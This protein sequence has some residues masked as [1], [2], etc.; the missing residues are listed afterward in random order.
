MKTLPRAPFELNHPRAWRTY[1]GGALLDELHGK[2]H[3]LDGHFPEEWIA[4]VISTRNPG[5][6]HMVNE[7]LSFLKDL[8]ECSLRACLESA[9]EKLLG[10]KHVQAYGAHPGVLVKLIDAAERLTIQVHPDRTAAKRLFNSPYGKT[11]CWHI[12]GGRSIH[13]E[14]PCVYL[15][16]QKGVTRET[17]Q[18]LFSVQDVE[19]MLSCLHRFE[20]SAGETILI[21]GGAPHAIGAGCFLVEIQE[22][23]DYT[24]RVERTTPSGLKVSDEACHQGLGF[25]AMFEC[26]HYEG[27]SRAEAKKRWFIPSKTTLQNHQAQITW[28]LDRD[29]T[30]FFAMRRLE[31]ISDLVLS[32]NTFSVLYIL[33]GRGAL[34]FGGSV[35]AL[36][37]P[38]QIFVPANAGEV[39]FHANGESLTILQFFGHAPKD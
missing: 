2:A 14:Q 13:G 16:F 15:G 11:E 36:Q 28:L 9:P 19:G 4:S 8:P 10:E 6:E 25:D 18:K 32:T 37:A 1:L 24:L 17:W 3:G 34:R 21:E 7:G 23:T 22:P 39:A 26:F 31:I 38:Q 27:L 20:V 35:L 12:L 29:S 30:S 33:E 5:R